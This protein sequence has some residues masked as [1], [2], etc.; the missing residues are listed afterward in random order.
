MERVGCGAD[1]PPAADHTL[2]LRVAMTVIM[3]EERCDR[4]SVA[5][6]LTASRVT[7]PKSG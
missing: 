5:R 2:S 6:I 1:Q 3:R 4:L 7:E